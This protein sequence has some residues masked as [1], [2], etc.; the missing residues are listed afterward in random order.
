MDTS[1]TY[2]K[3]AEGLPNKPIPHTA[4]AYIAGLIDGEGTISLRRKIGNHYNIEV[5]ITNTNL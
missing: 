2:I 1:E 4:I 3:M 5:Y